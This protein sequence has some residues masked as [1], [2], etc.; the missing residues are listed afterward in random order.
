MRN[1]R[2]ISIKEKI[3]IISQVIV[4][5]KIQPIAKKYKVSRPSIYVWRKR[6]L[7]SLEQALKPD[8][9]G[10]KFKK[11]KVNAK[12][13]VIEEQKEKIGKLNDIISEKEKQIKNLRNKI[14]LQ[15]NS[16]SRPS[17]CPHCGFEKIYKNG[18]YKIKPEKLFEQLKKGKEIEII[19]QQFIC[20][21]CRSSVY[22]EKEKRKIIIF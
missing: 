13:K 10:P 12:D 6:A 7:G 16:L 8:K 1:F 9:R 17:K 20:P 5:E 15:K 11:G 3:L 2:F 14:A 21:Y 4:G 18:T 22:R 19:T